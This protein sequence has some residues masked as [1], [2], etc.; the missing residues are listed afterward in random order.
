MSKYIPKKST[1]AEGNPVSLFPF[2]AVLLCTMGSLLGVLLSMADIAKQQAAAK[3]QSQEVQLPVL[4]SEDNKPSVNVQPEKTVA[5]PSAELLAAEIE[6]KTQQINQITETI[7]KLKEMRSLSEQKLNQSRLNL[8]GMESE[9]SQFKEEITRIQ[10]DAQKLGGEL[11]LLDMNS[12]QDKIAELEQ[13]LAAKKTQLQGLKEKNKDTKPGLAVIPHKGQYNTNRYPIYVMCT[14]EG[15][16]LQPEGILLEE[17]DFA[18]NLSLGSPLESALRAKREYLLKQGAFDPSRG[19]EPYPLILVRPDGVEY[20]YAAR[21]AISAFGNDFGYKLVDKKQADALVFPPVDAAMTQ[22]I[23]QAIVRA[24]LNMKEVAR[25]APAMESSPQGPVAYRVTGSG[26]REAVSLDSNSRVAEV[27]RRSSNRSGG[28]YANGGG[29]APNYASAN[30]GG[31][32]SG[33]NGGGEIII[34]AG[35]YNPQAQGKAGIGAENGVYLPLNS[36][37]GTDSTNSASSVGMF[38]GLA[39]AERI[40]PVTNAR[41]TALPRQADGGIPGAAPTIA[42]PAAPIGANNAANNPVANV[43]TWRPAGNSSPGQNEK[44]KPY[45]Q[46][47]SDDPAFSSTGNQNNESTY[48]QLLTPPPLPDDYVSETGA[49]S[50]SDGNSTRPSD[51][52]PLTQD[53]T[54]QTGRPPVPTGA[55]K[56]PLNASDPNNVHTKYQRSLADRLGPNWAIPEMNSRAISISRPI[57]VEIYADRFVVLPAAPEGKP[58]S[59]PIYGDTASSVEGLVRTVRSQTSLWGEAGTGS[60]WRPYLKVSTRQGGEKR[61][62]ELKSALENSGVEL[63]QN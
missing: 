63:E 31:N 29:N 45:N 57:R 23:Q 7:K 11:N 51:A 21:A 60:Y 62:A 32:K 47:V 43:D 18:C 41:T 5:D 42:F 50:A 28:S 22:T 24:R 1:S 25:I 61:L 17:G 35:S 2:L 9:I 19:E 36:P 44:G 12:L 10:N 15:V 58:I 56:E 20:Y 8:S 30:D 40:D 59:I 4:E 55:A 49:Q 13:T 38:A 6:Q 14:Q 37:D 53:D 33:S 39:E 16:V 52:C 54:E 3:A 46:L 34:G 26:S 48:N 27:L